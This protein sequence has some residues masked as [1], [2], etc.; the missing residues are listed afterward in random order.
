VGAFKTLNAQDVLISPLELNK[1]F[2]FDGVDSLINP[3]VNIERFLGKNVDFDL[4]KSTTGINNEQYQSLVYS[5][6]K[7]LYY[8]NYISGSNGEISLASTASFNPDTTITGPFY[9]TIYENY[10]QSDLDSKRFF[11]TSS[12]DVIG[13]LS[14]P[15]RLFGD[16]IQ[17]TTLKIV[18]GTNVYTDDGEGRIMF[19]SNFVGNIIYPHGIVIITGGDRSEI[20]NSQITDFVETSNIELSFSSSYTIYETQYKC[21]INEDEFNFSQNPSI[22]IDNNGNPLDFVG[23]DYFQPYVTTIGLYNDYKELIA[24]AKLSKPLMISPTTDTTILVSIDHL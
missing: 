5:Q 17:P 19:G 10:L 2:N 8:S 20:G 9:S 13:V 21:T 18:E 4:D 24:V 16:Y 1:G 11:P 3:Q 12:N 22:L 6:I 15:R 23:K 7:Q 14:I